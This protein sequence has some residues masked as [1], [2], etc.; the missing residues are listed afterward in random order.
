MSVNVH[1][2]ANTTLKHIRVRV[3]SLHEAITVDSME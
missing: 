2:V 3:H 1:W